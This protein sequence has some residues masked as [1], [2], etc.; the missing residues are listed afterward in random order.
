ML[1]S[2]SLVDQDTVGVLFKLREVLCK[3]GIIEIDARVQVLLDSVGIVPVKLG[4]RQFDQNFLD[5]WRYFIKHFLEL[6]NLLLFLIHVLLDLDPS[7]LILRGIIEDLLLLFIILLEL[8]ILSPQVLVYIN[9]VIDFLVENVHV[10]EQI[11]VLLFSLDESILDLQDISQTGSFLDR[12]EG[13]VNDLHVS[14]V[15]I[16][17][18][19]FLFVV[20]NKLG[21]SMLE[22][23]SR[24][25]LD[26]IDF[27]SLDPAAPIQLRIFKFLIQLSEPSVV[28]GLIFLVLHFEAQHQILTHLAGVLAG[29]DVLHE[30]VDLAISFLDII[31][32]R[33]QV[34]LVHRLFLPEQVDRVFKLRNFSHGLVVSLVILHSLNRTISICFWRL[35]IL[36]NITFTSPSSLSFFNC[37][38]VFL[39][40]SISPCSLDSTPC[41]VSRFRRSHSYFLV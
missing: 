4:S 20:N 33:F 34:V 32:K 25:V 24:I 36:V 31:L 9:K 5:E 41:R 10:G 3:I 35:R 22:Y 23:G 16:N 11:V 38:T 8:L 40:C 12:S 26:G 7:L 19:H 2:L 27:S 29:L 21:Q 15:V 6:I 17:Q 28:V 30:I 14:L 13:F 18:F 37:A 1:V 39:S